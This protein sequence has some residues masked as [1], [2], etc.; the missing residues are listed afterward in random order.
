V[1]Y[2]ICGL[3]GDRFDG[4]LLRTLDWR[5][6]ALRVT[7]VHSSFFEDRQRF[8]Q[9]SIEFDHALVMRDILHEWRRVEDPYAVSQ[10]A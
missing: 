9:G 5:V 6:R 1:P 3:D 2:E 7:E 10:A 4:L 8:P